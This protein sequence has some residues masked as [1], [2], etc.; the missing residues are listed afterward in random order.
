MAC[1]GVVAR[2]GIA[3][4]VGEEHA[5]R[6]QGQHFAGRGL[7]GHHGDA[8]T[9]RNQHAQDVQ[10]DAEVIGHHVIRQFGRSDFRVE[11]TLELPHAGAP[12]ITLGS[13]DFLGQVHALEAREAARQF[14]CFLF[15]GVVAHQ[16]AAI[17]RA[18]LTQDA[19]QATG[20]DTGDGHGAVLFQ[21]GIQRLLVA[22]ARRQQRQVTND[23]TGSP[24]AV[25]FGVFR[26]GAGV[27]DVRVGQGNDLLGIGRI[28]EDFLIAGHGRIEHDLTNGMTIGSNGIAAKNAAVSKGEYGWLSQ[29]DLP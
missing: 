25:G 15:S 24:H 7:G 22:P 13:G 16:N 2:L 10:L 23:Q 1:N 3:G 11:V 5:I 9:A 21:I 17:L 19:G 26:R 29:E 28:G 6:I 20:I 8:A 12:L 18:F 4:A 14:Q 27:T